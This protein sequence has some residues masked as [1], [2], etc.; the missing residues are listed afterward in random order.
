MLVLSEVV[1]QPP[2]PAFPRGQRPPEISV[3]QVSAVRKDVS[4]RLLPGTA[5]EEDARRE[6]P[7]LLKVS[8]EVRGGVRPGGA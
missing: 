7:R 2:L 3:G 5:R 8:K 1:P 4:R 6:E